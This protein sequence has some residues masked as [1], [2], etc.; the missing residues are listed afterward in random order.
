MRKPR[1]KPCKKCGE[2]SKI[3]LWHYGRMKNNAGGGTCERCSFK[4]KKA[5][6]PW[7]MLSTLAKIWN[8]GQ[9]LT[10]EEKLRRALKRANRTIRNLREE[11]YHAEKAINGVQQSQF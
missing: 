1:V 9:C 11:L 5:I 3:H 6:G 7:P 10:T 8:D 2:K 4:V